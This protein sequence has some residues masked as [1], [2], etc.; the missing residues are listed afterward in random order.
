RYQLKH[1]GK[2]VDAVIDQR[3]DG[4]VPVTRDHFADFWRRLAEAFGRE[5]AVGAYGLVNEPHDMGPSDWKA[6]SQAAVDAI[7]SVDRRTTILVPGDSYSNSERWAEVNGPKAWIKDPSDRLAYE[8]HCYFDHDYSG[9][10]AKSYDA[11]LA[12]DKDLDRRGVRRL[13]PFVRWCSSN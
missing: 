4:A 1:A 5:K 10:Y 8:A 12:K 13:Q 9:S 6:I 2:V 11:E 3:I 7:R